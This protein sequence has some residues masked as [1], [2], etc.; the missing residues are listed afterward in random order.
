[1]TRRPSRQIPLALWST[2]RQPDADGASSTCWRDT[3]LS[4]IAMVEDRALP[5]TADSGPVSS[6][7]PADVVT[8]RA[9]LTTP[10]PSAVLLVYA[11]APRCGRPAA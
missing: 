1:M 11:W 3:L 9:V 4:L 7:S 5:I 8:R 6:A 2:T 10:S